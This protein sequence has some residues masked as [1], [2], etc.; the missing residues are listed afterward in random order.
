MGVFVYRGPLPPDSPLFRGRTAE[1]A[2]LIRLCQ[3]EVEAYAIVYGGR[4]TG[5]TS[6]LLRLAAGLPKTVRTCRVDFQWVPG[7]TTRQ[8]F[9]YLARRVARSLPDLV[10]APEVDDAPS[11]VEFLSEAIDQPEISRLVL[12][13]EELGAL[14][15]ASRN[16]LAH[17]LRAVFTN[18][19][20]PSCRPLA[21]LMV[22]IAGGVE[23]YD[24]AATQVSPLQNCCEAMYLPD[25]SEPE[26][27]GLIA[28]GLTRLRLPHTEAE[29]LGEAIYF[30]VGGHPYLTQRLGGALEAYL[31]TGE[32]PKPAHVDTAAERLLSG[33]PLLHHL[34]RALI[35]E[36][37]L[38][39]SKALLDGNLRF[40][41]LDEDMAR[42]ELL[43]LAT[44][45]NGY[46]KVRNRLL[47]R[48]LE[49]WLAASR[50]LDQDHIDLAGTIA[51][52]KPVCVFISSTW[53]DLQPEREAVEDALHR[54]QETAFAG[55]EYF[56]SRP[57]TPREVSLA[58][59]DRSHVY[60][61]IFAHRY[62]SG[63]TEAEYRRARE[64]DIP[65]LIYLKDDSVAVP[66]AYI[67][68]EPAKVAKLEALKCELEVHH[69]VST[70]KS[71]DHLATQVVTDLHNLLGSAPTV[72]EEEP[73]YTRN[74]FEELRDKILKI[75]YDH[76]RTGTPTFI[77]ASQIAEE[78]GLTTIE[79][80]EQLEI[81]EWH[82][83]AKLAKAGAG[84]H[85]AR[86]TPLGKQRVKEGLKS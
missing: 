18:R 21:R 11:L 31:A 23:L 35:E 39:A 29:A 37:L 5:K 78:L 24:L 70:F 34:R 26:A 42:L 3:G 36:D 63:I 68:R 65:C 1:L 50:D 59:V 14:P 8:V 38:G 51:R 62:G 56:G 60:I 67:G 82:Q 12:L 7:A 2:R 72:R 20:D 33:N 79:I 73:S 77:E 22:V 40:S 30:H 19:F 27:V 6:L 81:L 55:M 64:R 74:K 17:V 86:L 49:D 84:N 46:W 9:T 41:R 85:G 28:D 80:D 48:A 54:M 57:E 45:A 44:E 32:L 52:D 61:G 47:A 83:Y 43:G 4:Q 71:P 15:Q 75:I 76:E 69:T 25:L 66:P 13:L 16:D 58:E 10:A 53:K